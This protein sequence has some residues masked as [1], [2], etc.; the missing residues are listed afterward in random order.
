MLH[1][2]RNTCTWL[3]HR[4][5]TTSSIPGSLHNAQYFHG[6]PGKLARLLITILR[7]DAF[8]I[9]RVLPLPL[10]LRLS[11]LYLSLWFFVILLL[12]FPSERGVRQLCVA[13]FLY[14]STLLVAL[15]KNTLQSGI[16]TDGHHNI[17][18][19]VSSEIKLFYTLHCISNTR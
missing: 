10:S 6:S 19:R 1:T 13:G 7:N 16:V 8:F 2:W 12:S 18:I 14:M 11:W 3:L 4:L 5:T 15:L 9:K 17:S